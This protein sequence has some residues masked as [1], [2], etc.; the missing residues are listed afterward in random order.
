MG[1][2]YTEITTINMYLLIQIGYDII[3]N[4]MG[5]YSELEKFQLYTC[6]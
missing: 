2:Q 1:V 6:N 4:A 5:I 3:D